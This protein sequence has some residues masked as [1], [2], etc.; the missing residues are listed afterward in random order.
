MAYPNGS[1]TWT[2]ISSIPQRTAEI[3]M[4]TEVVHTP[5]EPYRENGSMVSHTNRK[6]AVCLKERGSREI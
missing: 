6:R 4:T 2:P 3:P 5:Q 1:S